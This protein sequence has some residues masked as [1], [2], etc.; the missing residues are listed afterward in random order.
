MKTLPTITNQQLQIL[1]LLYRYRFLHRHHIQ[2]LLNHKNHHL[3]LTWLKDLETKGYIKSRISIRLGAI[4][5]PTLYFLATKSKY[6]LND[7]EGISPAFLERIYKE[8][9]KTKTFIDRCLTIAD[10]N[11]KISNQ[12]GR[13]SLHFFPK[14]DLKSYRY[15]PHPLPDAYL[16]IKSPQ[17]TTR[18]FV[19]VIDDSIPRFVIRKRIQQYVEYNDDGKWQEQNDEQLPSILLVC[20]D[21]N[22][23]KFL[24]SYIAEFL[25]DEGV[26]DMHFYLTGQNSSKETKKEWQKVQS[27]A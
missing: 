14:R 17:E 12:K 1:I 11:I 16:S 8:A 5:N 22:T 24:N 19:D 27:S 23:Q 9:Y 25:D 13:E 26:T 6:K 4:L 21:S 18:Y 20:S 10:L 3:I 15:F 7:V 2:Y